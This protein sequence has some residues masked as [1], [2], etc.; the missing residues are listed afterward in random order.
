M[1]VGRKLSRGAAIGRRRLQV[2]FEEVGSGMIGLDPAFLGEEAVNFIGE[3]ELLKWHILFPKSFDQGDGLVEGYV[4][5]VIAVNKQ[6]RRTPSADGREGRRFK[7]EVR[8]S[9]VERET[10]GSQLGGPVVDAVKIDAD[11]EEV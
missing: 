10:V 1:R 9:G 2:F 3:D 7:G 11:G 4:A 6:D 5:I 8:R